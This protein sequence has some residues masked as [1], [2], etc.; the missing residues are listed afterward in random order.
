MKGLL[1][2]LLLIT[3]YSC[4]TDE[5][6]TIENPAENPQLTL[7]TAI[8]NPLKNRDYT[9]HE[10]GAHGVFE[11]PTLQKN[12]KA[13]IV[14]TNNSTASN[15]DLK[16]KWKSD[17]DGQ[18][19]EGNPNTD[20]ESEI[21]VNLSKGLHKILF[22]VYS[23]TALI[24]KDS[25]Y[26]SNVITLQGIAKTGISVNLEWSKYEGNDFVSYLI[27]G[28]SSQPLAEINDINTLEFEYFET[29]SMLA[30]RNYQ[31]VV[32]T[33]N[34]TGN[35]ING[36]NIIAIKSGVF[37]EIPYFITK[38]VNDEN[39]GKIYGIIIPRNNGA[40]A[41]LIA[42]DN[43]NLSLISHTLQSKTFSDLDISPDGQFL[44]LTQRYVEEITKINLNTMSIETFAT[45]TSNWGFHKIEV[46]NN[47][48]LYCHITPP[49]SGSTGILI[50]NAQN[51]NEIN[52]S[53]YAYGHGDIAFNSANGSLYHGESNT[54][55]GRITKSTY[56]NN[57]LNIDLAYP[58]F[59]ENEY[60]VSYPYPYLFISKDNNSI[61]WE[62][63][64][65]DSN[66]NLTRQFNTKIVSCSPNNLYLSDLQKVYDYTN[67]NVVFSFPPFPVNENTRTLLFKDD[68]T[69]ITSK[70]YRPN[71]TNYDDK[72]YIFKMKFN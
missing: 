33:A 20:L 46:G 62:N 63:F 41:G 26:I 13:K 19:F 6:N 40:V 54:S 4:S 2:T 71:I 29:I 60:G 15:T 42:F 18:L 47:N 39:N 8:V 7:T 67:L 22:E 3:L 45:S 55:G 24:E 11:D 34:T 68:H 23:N 25:I 31:I 56:S 12:L 28:V 9:Y 32:K 66:L 58:S 52:S 49:T 65:L 51:G 17:I 64:Q 10:N 44:Y 48:L 35:L 5:N 70:A 53:Y 16:V 1:F 57:F 38:I 59:A 61:F 21:N 50:L 37:A 27:Y 72:T 43:E 36:S 30:N 69:I 14:L